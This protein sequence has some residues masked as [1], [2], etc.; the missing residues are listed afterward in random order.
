MERKIKKD[1]LK[2]ID[3]ARK[4]KGIKWLQIY[5]KLDITKQGF[6]YHKNNLK[7][8]KITFSVEQINELSEFLGVDKSIFF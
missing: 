8:N 4:N 3:E 7:K 2:T 1:I 6:Q 5:K